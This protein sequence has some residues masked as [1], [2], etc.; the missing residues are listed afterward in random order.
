MDSEDYDELIKAEEAQREHNWDPLVRWQVIQRMIAWADSQ[1][2][3]E[4]TSVS[5]A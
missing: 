1:R 4:G 2:T 3:G 5:D